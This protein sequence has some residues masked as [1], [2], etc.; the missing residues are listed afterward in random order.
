MKKKGLR[1]EELRATNYVRNF[2]GKEGEVAELGNF[3]YFSWIEEDWSGIPLTEEWIEKLGFFRTTDW[4][5]YTDKFKIEKQALKPIFWDFR[6]VTGAYSSVKIT[7]L[8]YVHQL[9]NLYFALTGE[10]LVLADA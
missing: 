10:E 9:Q 3:S 6:C 2:E 1:I 5:F 4:L 8:K 7:S